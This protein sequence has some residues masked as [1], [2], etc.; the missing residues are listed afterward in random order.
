MV[1]ILKTLKENKKKTVSIYT[2][3]KYPAL[4][5]EAIYTNSTYQR[6]IGLVNFKR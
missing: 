3:C 5:A 1:R 4:L 2:K 6:V